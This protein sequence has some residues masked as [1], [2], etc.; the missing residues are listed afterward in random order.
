LLWETIN[1]YKLEGACRFNL[2]GCKIEAT[3][4]TSPEHGVYVYKRDFGGER[5]EC[6]S[7]TKVLRKIR[8]GIVRA[9]RAIFGR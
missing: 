2:S 5:I 3:K 4:E 9:G 1:R 8:R 6:A 7:G